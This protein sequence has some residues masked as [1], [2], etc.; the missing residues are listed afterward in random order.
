MEAGKPPLLSEPLHGGQELQDREVWPAYNP[1]PVRIYG[2]PRYP[3]QQIPDIRQP[4]HYH[5]YGRVSHAPAKVVIFIR[6]DKALQK[7]RMQTSEHPFG[8]I[9]HYDGASYFLCRGKEKVAAETALMYLSYNIRRAI[10][11]AG[12]VQRLIARCR[13]FFSSGIPMPI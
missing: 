8:T 12:G 1:V 9:K 3:L 2:S 13:V 6:R 7:E 11:L 10:R 4:D 5:A